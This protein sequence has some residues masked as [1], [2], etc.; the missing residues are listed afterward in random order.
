MTKGRSANLIME[1]IYE[2]KPNEKNKKFMRPLIITITAIA[3]LGFL[4]LLGWRLLHKEPLTGLSGL[5]VVNRP[6]PDFTLTTYQKT[7]FTLSDLKG[8]PVVINFWASWCPPCRE[9]AALLEWAWRAYKD[10]GVAF[11][12]VDIQDTKEAAQ[13]YLRAFNVTYPNGLDPEGEISIDYGVSGIPVTFFISPKGII[14]RRW[15][16]AITEKALLGGIEEL[17]K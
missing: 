5:N 14:T 10:R 4:A 15:V 9:E 11:I 13:K 17:R 3:L 7:K 8:K 12:G 2:D 1:H 16:G 6:A